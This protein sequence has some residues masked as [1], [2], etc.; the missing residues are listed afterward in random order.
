M[1]SVSV[2]FAIVESETAIGVCEFAVGVCESRME[3]QRGDQHQKFRL[4]ITPG[5]P[6]ENW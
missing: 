4:R 5:E 1:Q 3:G 2:A 6:G